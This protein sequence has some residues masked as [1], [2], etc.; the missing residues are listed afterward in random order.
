V[1]CRVGGLR[2]PSR[3]RD[4]LVAHVDERHPPTSAS[5][6]LEVEHAP[7]P[8]ERLLDV[9]DLEGYVVD[10]EQTRHARA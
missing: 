6:Q 2:P 10:A 7:V 8:R 3:E 9:V 1:P 4:E 5:A